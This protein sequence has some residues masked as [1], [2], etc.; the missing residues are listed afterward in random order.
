VAKHWESF[1]LPDA[2]FNP[3]IYNDENGKIYFDA[4]PD[5]SGYRIIF[6]G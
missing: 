2:L 5:L 3:E 6:P 1:K 4:L